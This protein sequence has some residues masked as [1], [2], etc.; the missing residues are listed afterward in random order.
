MTEQAHRRELQAPG[1]DEVEVIQERQAQA[2]EA[3]PADKGDR[4]SKMRSYTMTDWEIFKFDV[5]LAITDIGFSLLC[6]LLLPLY[7]LALL[8]WKLQEKK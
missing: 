3:A 7:P 6:I 5:W 1:T 4:V 2:P 8:C